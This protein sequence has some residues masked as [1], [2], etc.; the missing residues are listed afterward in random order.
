MPPRVQL[1]H[2]EYQVNTL[3]GGGARARLPNSD[4]ILQSA[5]GQWRANKTELNER[6]WRLAALCHG[7]VSA[8]AGNWAEAQKAYDCN[9]EY[10]SRHRT[11]A[12]PE[13]AKLDAFMCLGYAVA[14]C[15]NGRPNAGPVNAIN[16]QALNYLEGTRDTRFQ[17]WTAVSLIVQALC[18]VSDG[19]D[20]YGKTATRAMLHMDDSQPELCLIAM[21]LRGEGNGIV[22][23]KMLRRARPASLQAAECLYY[24]NENW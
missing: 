1:S 15:V 22:P 12:S 9:P 16:Q 5:R 6:L 7:A 19:R 17:R 24:F 13:N 23:G 8:F 18:E 10:I 3:R 11:P 4:A 21:K 20:V 2:V 14:A